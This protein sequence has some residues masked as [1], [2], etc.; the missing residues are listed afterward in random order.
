[1]SLTPYWRNEEH[2]LR[3][4]CGDCLEVLPALAEAGESFDFG[5]SSPPYA[6]GLEYEEG[7][8]WHG[9][10]DLIEALAEVALSTFRPSAFFMVNFGETT[11]YERTMAELYNTA[12]RDAGWLMHSR[13]I[14]KKPFAMTKFSAAGIHLT[15]PVA[16]WEYIWAFRKPPNAKE[17]FR[18]RPLTIRAVWEPTKAEYETAVCEKHCA[19]FPS[20]LP[21]WGMEAW[22]DAGDLILD[23][24]LGSGTTLVAAY[25]L[26]RRATGIEISEEYCALAAERLE[27][28]LAQG[29]L[30]EPSEVAQPTQEAFAL[31]GV[32]AQ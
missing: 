8:D 5:V 28:E 16:E 27:R 9:L 21:S 1:M 18:K 23:P 32:S 17:V 2:G 20:Y 14:W 25:R 3:I 24:F 19:A 10:R 12:W 22:T 4:F 31:E 29:R 15:I 13:R 30:F 7:L 11:K 26:G 6:Q